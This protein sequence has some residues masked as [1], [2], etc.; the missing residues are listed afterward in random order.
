MIN[1][2]APPPCGWSCGGCQHFKKGCAG[3]RQTS[4]TPFWI[5][6]SPMDR[7]P[8]YECCT[9]Q[10]GLEHCGL[11]PDLP[12]ETFLKLRDP[13]MSD[14]EFEKSLTERKAALLKRAG[15]GPKG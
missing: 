3:C 15:A 8:V 13:S 7:C 4:G 1:N 5:P 10:K 9:D 2:E 12:C 6:K 11:C 14:E